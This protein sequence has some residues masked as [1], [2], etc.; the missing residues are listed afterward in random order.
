M[1]Y[2]KYTYIEFDIY[3]TVIVSWRDLHLYSICVAYGCV[4]T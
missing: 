4:K 2:L 3:T 1:L